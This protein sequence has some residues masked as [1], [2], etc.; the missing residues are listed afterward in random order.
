MYTCKQSFTASNGV[1][2][3]GKQNITQIEYD[4]LTPEDQVNFFKAYY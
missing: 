2:Y 1:H 3:S 4:S